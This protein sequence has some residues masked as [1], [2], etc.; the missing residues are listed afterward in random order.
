MRW[1]PSWSL[2]LLLVSCV[3]F[4]PSDPPPEPTDPGG[5]GSSGSGGGSGSGTDPATARRQAFDQTVYPIL[6][7]K[8]AQC[9]EQGNALA[10]L[11]FVT[12]D[13]T[14]AYDLIKT[15]STLLGQ[16]VFT[17]LL[18]QS[19]ADYTAQETATLSAWVALENTP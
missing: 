1:V 10:P 16:P 11:E 15:F 7:A 18:N 14:R 3:S 4:D 8:C 12:L 6:T 2:A 5:S 13:R 9:H 17:D 19:F